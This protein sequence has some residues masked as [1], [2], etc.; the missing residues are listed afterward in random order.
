MS[1]SLVS[2][3]KACNQIT[4]RSEVRRM[5]QF[6]LHAGSPLED[7]TVG[8][9]ARDVWAWQG[10]E[11]CPPTFE[12]DSRVRIGF[13]G[14]QIHLGHVSLARTAAELARNRRVL[15]FDANR[16]WAPTVDTFLKMLSH[17]ADR[18]I[19][20]LVEQT[21][22]TSREFE[23]AAMSSIRLGR[24]RRVYGWDDA[25]PG[26]V[27]TD[28]MTMVSFFLFDPD[29]SRSHDLALVDALQAP[30][31]AWLA[32]VARSTGTLPPTLLYRRLFPSLRRAGERASV[33]DPSSVVFVDDDDET[34]ARKFT[35]S[36]TGGRATVSEQ[37]QR[38]GDPTRC[39]AFATI[40]LLCTPPTANAALS[41][42]VSGETTCRE[43]K[44][45]HLPQVV[46]GVRDVVATSAPSP[47]ITS[48]P[49][50]V[51]RA[52]A[53][54]HICPPRHPDDLEALIAGKHGVDP[55][56]V[57]IGQ[58]STQIMD[59][60]FRRQ[61]AHGSRVVVTEPTFELYRQLAARHR[62]EYVAAPCRVD[63]LGHDAPSLARAIDDSTT[64]C[65]LDLPH[66]VSGSCADWAVVGHILDS[67]AG[68]SLLVLDMVYADFV[69]SDIPSLPTL[70]ALDP[71]IVV[72]RSFSKAHYLLG[73][74]VGYA[75]CHRD[76]A[77]EL[78][79]GRLPYAMSS[80]ALA[81]AEAAVKDTCRLENAVSESLIARQRVV[82]ALG[83]L[84]VT[85]AP[86]EGNFIL[87]NLK[88]NHAA[89]ATALASAGQRFRDGRRWGLPGWIQIHLISVPQVEPILV[90]L[91]GVLSARE[92]PAPS[93]ALEIEDRDDKPANAHR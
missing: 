37:R 15:M 76:L 58:G 73:A 8:S 64:L 45:A 11:A 92:L 20:I 9:T 42:C 7:L 12:P 29:Q 54:L 93:Q 60:V 47:A 38:G 3:N 35:R 63:T 68:D 81:A 82:T 28:F 10:F 13:A 41:A 66:T 77:A 57:V 6:G 22:G 26:A 90:V 78:R 86:P 72:C 43:C 71:R 44:L 52:A 40:E 75:V 87:M 48:V 33:H 49:R 61:A 84:G 32:E 5:R 17:F 23:R 50:A 24:L 31:S 1:S 14:S 2:W 4:A 59:W 62:L 91:D 85:Y 19:S 74:R 51:A 18:P 70:L 88:E 39:P 83:R 36:L 56:E 89:V 67:L 55:A 30:H 79:S 16:E 25:T 34:I 21:D 53:N 80:L 65:V 46:Q 27:L 69:Q